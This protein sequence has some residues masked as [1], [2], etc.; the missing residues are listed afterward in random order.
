LETRTPEGNGFKWGSKG[1]Q[2]VQGGRKEIASFLAMTY[3]QKTK[4][5][6]L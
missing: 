5:Y 1:V 6:K 2:R 4:N 3:E